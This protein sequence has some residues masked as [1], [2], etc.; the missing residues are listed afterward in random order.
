LLDTSMTRHTEKSYGKLNTKSIFNYNP[1]PDS[2]C[3]MASLNGPTAPKKLYSE[4][5]ELKDDKFQI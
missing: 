2:I 4:L 5:R 3:S 1:P